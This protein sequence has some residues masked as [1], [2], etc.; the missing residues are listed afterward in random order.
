MKNTEEHKLSN[1]TILKVGEY[2]T[3][4]MI[5]AG[6]RTK[7]N[8]VKVLELI[9]GGFIASVEWSNNRVLYDFE[10]AT[11]WDWKVYTTPK[12]KILE[13][14]KLFALHHRHDNIVEIEF[15]TKKPIETDC[16]DVYTIEEAKELG[17]DM[18]FLNK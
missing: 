9:V 17:L 13:K 5:N 11:D 2:Y 12:K 10:S 3:S 16:M 4:P 6:G 15:H 14:Y 7:E 8:R 18:N 1:G